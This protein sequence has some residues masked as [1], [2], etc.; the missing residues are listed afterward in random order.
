M[1]SSIS[2]ADAGCFVE[3]RR[4]GFIREASTTADFFGISF[5]IDLDVGM[6]AV[7]LGACMQYYKSMAILINIHHSLP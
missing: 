1:H 2:V 6:K 4:S 3:W 5:P 7:M